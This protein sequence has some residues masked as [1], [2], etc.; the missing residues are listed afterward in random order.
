MQQ[1]FCAL[2][3]IGMVIGKMHPVIQSHIGF[4]DGTIF[5]KETI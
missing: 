1:M 2:L 5:N 3:F 4:K